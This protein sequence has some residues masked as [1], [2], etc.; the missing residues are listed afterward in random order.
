M[1]WEGVDLTQLN[2]KRDWWWTHEQRIEPSVSVKGREF[3]D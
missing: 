3:F 1:G 2:H